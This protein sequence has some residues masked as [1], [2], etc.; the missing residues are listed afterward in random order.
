MA[1]VSAGA[2]YEPWNWVV[3]T[4]IHIDDGTIS[5]IVAVIRE[6]ADQTKLLALNA[7]IEAAP[8]GEQG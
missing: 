8:A 3:A 4:G 6:V 1:K 5:S 2:L 7:A